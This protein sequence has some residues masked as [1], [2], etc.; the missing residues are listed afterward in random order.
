LVVSVLAALLGGLVSKLIGGA[1]ATLLLAALAL[2]LGAVSAYF[3]RQRVIPPA[4][5]AV[6][7]N[8][9]ARQNAKQ[10]GWLLLLLPVI[11]AAGVLA[12]ARLK[13]EER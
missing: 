13:S 12:G 8:I 4:R 7:G 11:G 2:L 9:E 10:P 5:A 3:D 6:V 1:K